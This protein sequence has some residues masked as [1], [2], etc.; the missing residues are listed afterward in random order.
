MNIMLQIQVI[1]PFALRIELLIIYYVK[2]NRIVLGDSIK[3]SENH[4]YINNV[5]QF[6]GINKTDYLLVN[7]MEPDHSLNSSDNNKITSK[8]QNNLSKDMLKAF[9]GIEEKMWRSKME[10][11]SVIR[12]VS[13]RFIKTIK[14]H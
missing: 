3:L 9:Y 4:G 8:Y 13:D 2:I 14:P 11:L 5:K 10:K 1:T 6:I 12:K 7:A